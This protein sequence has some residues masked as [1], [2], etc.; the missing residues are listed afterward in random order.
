MAAKA[1][2]SLNKKLI[3]TF[4]GVDFNFMVTP[5][6]YIAYVNDLQ[7]DDKVTPHHGLLMATIDE[8]QK[9]DLAEILMF[10][11]VVMS[12]GAKLIKLYSEGVEV[13]VKK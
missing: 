13:S 8:K 2:D 6:A 9:D 7:S 12:A 4:D 1:S 5:G 10:P 3:L 11:P